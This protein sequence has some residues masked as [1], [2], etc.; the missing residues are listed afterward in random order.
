MPKTVKREK[1]EGSFLRKKQP[2]ISKIVSKKITEI[3]W[4]DLATMPDSDTD[5][6]DSN[7]ISASL[8]RV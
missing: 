3:H 7:H 1:Q 8:L 2:N 5:F 6:S 4:E